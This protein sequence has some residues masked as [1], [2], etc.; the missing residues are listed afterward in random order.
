MSEKVA[1]LGLGEMGSRMAENLIKAGFEVSVYNRTASRADPLVARGARRADTP[2]DALERA[3]L[4][5]SMLSDDRALE[6]VVESPGFLDRLAGGG[7][8]V[9]MSTISPA[10]SRRLAAR[11]SER[12]GAWVAA[13][14]FGRPEAA[15]AR[16]LWIVASG[17]ATARERARPILERLGQGVFE[18]GE[19]AGAANVVKLCG[20]FLIGAMLEGMGEAFTLAEKNGI[21]R[22]EIASVLGDTLFG[23]PVFRG[24]APAVAEKRF[25]PAGFKLALG[26]KDIALVLDAASQAR[27]PMPLASLVHGRLLA[28]I[29]RGRG[30][31]DWSALALAASEDAGLT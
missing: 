25:S 31:L 6:E 13:P 7:V 1:F 8:H 3:G 21:S 18:F 17:P 10:A 5:V 16:K 4:A 26:W 19:D 15:A 23:A 29:A 12:G 27:V 28:G 24:Y 11:H 2:A 30:D 22:S 20:N 14:V 9:S